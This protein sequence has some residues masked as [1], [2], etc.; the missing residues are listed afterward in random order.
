MET[1]PYLGECYWRS[2]ALV[3][4]LMDERSLR[5]HAVLF[6]TYCTAQQGGKMNF[7]DLS[8]TQNPSEGAGRNS[9]IGR[10]L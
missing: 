7:G 6:E 4:Q 2:L 1:G 8:R 10:S 9:G 3:P 5:C